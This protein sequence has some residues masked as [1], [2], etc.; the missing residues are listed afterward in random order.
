MRAIEALQDRRLLGA[1]KDARAAARDEELRAAHPRRVVLAKAP[2]RYGFTVTPDEPPDFERVPIEGAFDLRVIAECAGEPV[3]DIRTLNPEL[4]RLATPADR[5]FSLRVPPGRAQSV[6]ACVAD[7]PPEKRVNF[8]KAVVRRGQTFASIAR[9]NGTT[10][11]D[12]AEANNLP[13]RSACEPGTELIIPIPAKPRVAQ[14]RARPRRRRPTRTGRVRYRIQPGDTLAS[15]AAQHGTTVRDIQASNGLRGSRIAA[16]DVLTIDTGSATGLTGHPTADLARPTRVVGSDRRRLSPAVL[17]G[18]DP[19]SPRRSPPPFSA[20][21][22][23]SSGSRPTPLP[24]S[25]ASP[26]SGS[27]TPP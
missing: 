15:I 18:R 20:S 10:A 14:A 8:R 4:R 19:C 27:P 16:G 3:E 26:W 23:T 6:A 7:L 21:R 2:E 9:A 22:P 25:P 12:V 11:R 17:R 5:T 1:A 24:A 13:L